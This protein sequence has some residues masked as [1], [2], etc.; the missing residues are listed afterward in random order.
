MSIGDQVS[1]SFVSESS[2][3]LSNVF[4]EYLRVLSK[5]GSYDH[6]GPPG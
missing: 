3:F 4:C 1:F 6:R 2:E 5:D